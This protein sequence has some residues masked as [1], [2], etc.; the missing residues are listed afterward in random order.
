MI[1]YRHLQKA[2][3]GQNMNAR[4]SLSFNNC[5]ARAQQDESTKEDLNKRHHQS[6][7]Q[8]ILGNN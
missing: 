1:A 3:A 7:Q 2:K 5:E 4:T 8:T 6:G